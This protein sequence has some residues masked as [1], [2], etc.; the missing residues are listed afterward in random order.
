[1]R[2]LPAVPDL[3]PYEG[4]EELVLDRVVAAVQ[5]AIDDISLQAAYYWDADNRAWE[6]LVESFDSRLKPEKW[7]ADQVALA[8]VAAWDRGSQ[9][10]VLAELPQESGG[11]IVA[12]FLTAP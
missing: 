6:E 4:A 12:L 3:S 7:A 9:R 1:M 8:G 11:R 2:D 10:L 5:T